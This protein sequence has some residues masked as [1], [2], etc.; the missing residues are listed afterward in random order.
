[1]A[2]DGGRI[3]VAVTG[4]LILTLALGAPAHALP[5][6]FT[7]FTNPHPPMCCGTIGF[8]YAGNKFVGSVQADGTGVVLYSTDLSGGSVA[9]F[10]PTVNIPSG[11][12]SSEHYVSSSLGLG[13]FPSRDIYVAAGNGIIHIN[14]A[15]T[16]SSVFVPTSGAGSLASPVRGILF[17]A[18]GTFGGDMLVTTNGGQVYRINSAGTVSLLASVGEDTE[19]LDIAPLGAG[20]GGFDGQLIVASE[21]S[22]KI[23]AISNTG[24]VTDLGLTI[25]NGPEELSFVPL[26]LGLSG[27]PVE[28]FYGSRYTQDVLFAGAGEFAGLQGDVIVTS[29]F[30]GNVTR[31]HW[32]GSSF[33]TSSIG[34]FGGQPE[35]GIFVTVAIIRGGGVPEPASLLLLGSGLAGLGLLGWRRGRRA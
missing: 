18:V 16:A 22:G 19:G 21:G 12:T 29:E 32:N 14:N 26:D 31:I 34:N 24:V 13:G 25:A 23:R 28:G 1:M 3:A 30:S 33:V 9:V 20:F 10:A 2:K 15:G 6:T 4:L 27:D 17:D 11:S 5:I 35:D 7:V 8:A